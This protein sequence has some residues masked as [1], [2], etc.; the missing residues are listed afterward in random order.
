MKVIIAGGR[1]ITDYEAL[2]KAIEN[3]GFEITE[4]ISGGAR[5]VDYMGE[6]Y[7]ESN[8]IPLTK[9]P[10]NWEKFGKAAGGIR[11]SE[12]I[13]YGAEALIALWDGFSSGTADMIDK[14]RWAGLKTHIE[15]YGKLQEFS[16]KDIKRR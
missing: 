15:Y 5:G 2:L 11:N 9:K 3:S 6:W 7:A 12:M 13:N 14:S 1:E 8:N 10:A 16:T 4:V